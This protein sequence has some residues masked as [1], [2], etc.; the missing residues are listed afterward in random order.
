MV[1]SFQAQRGATE[2]VG[3]PVRDVGPR[4]RGMHL[5]RLIRLVHPARARSY[6]LAVID[7]A[8]RLRLDFHG[9]L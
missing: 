1:V 9:A 3:I 5:D 6:S 7:E 2:P 8:N 4:S